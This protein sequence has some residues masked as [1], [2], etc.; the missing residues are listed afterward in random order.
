MTN[1]SVVNLNAHFMSPGRPNLYILNGEILASL[2][3]NRRLNASQPAF[4]FPMPLPCNA[5]PIG[6]ASVLFPTHTKLIT[7]R[8]RIRKPSPAWAMAAYEMEQRG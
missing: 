1:T 3:S 7:S 4:F 6:L 2:P 8:L 5:I